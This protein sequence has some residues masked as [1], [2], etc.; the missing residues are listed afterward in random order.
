MSYTT[1]KEAFQI[2]KKR[3]HEQVKPLFYFNESQAGL[4]FSNTTEDYTSWDKIQQHYDKIDHLVDFLE[5]K[6]TNLDYDYNLNTTLRDLKLHYLES[7]ELVKIYQ[8]CFEPFYNYVELGTFIQT[9]A[10]TKEKV[11]TLFSLGSDYSEEDKSAMQ[12]I[13][14]M[15]S[16]KNWQNSAPRFVTAFTAQE[17]KDMIMSHLEHSKGVNTLKTTHLV[18]EISPFMSFNEGRGQFIAEIMDKFL[19]PREKRIQEEENFPVTMFNLSFMEIISQADIYEIANAYS[20]IDYFNRYVSDFSPEL[21][22]K[23]IH[24]SYSEKTEANTLQTPFWRF[25]IESNNPEP[26]KPELFKKIYLSFFDLYQQTKEYNEDM[27][28]DGFQNHI[29]SN[30]KLAENLI[31]FHLMNHRVPARTESTHT[32]M[33][34]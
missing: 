21:N 23:R 30:P 7:H 33:K 19:A 34:I 3:L 5:G 13:N 17:L 22:I 4:L 24:S 8:N 32:R 14:N 10:N 18:H 28:I 12:F 15:S 20:L 25:F 1:L 27:S 9:H 31:L 6:R 16:L 2:D 26:V 11:Q 29:A